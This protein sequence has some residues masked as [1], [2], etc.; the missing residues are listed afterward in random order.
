[1]LPGVAFVGNGQSVVV[2]LERADDLGEIGGEP[3]AQCV[4]EGDGGNDDGD[5]DEAALD[6]V[7][8]FIGEESGE[9]GGDDGGQGRLLGWWG[10]LDATGGEGVAPVEYD[11]R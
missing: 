2:W 4:P 11:R 6:H 8:T 10:R 7:P 9:G 1:M 5:Q 3:V